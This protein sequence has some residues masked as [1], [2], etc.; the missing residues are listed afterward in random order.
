VQLCTISGIFINAKI[1]L[2]WINLANR[3]IFQNLHQEDSKKATNEKI[4]EHEQLQQTQ[5]TIWNKV[6]PQC[7]QLV[8]AWEAM[9]NEKED[10]LRGLNNQE[11]DVC[12][13]LVNLKKLLRSS[14]QQAMT[15]TPLPN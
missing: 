9:K 13:R 1:V 4:K 7:Q 14:Q 10:I 12:R 2:F 3:A 8:K 5:K 15:S 6:L 11:Q